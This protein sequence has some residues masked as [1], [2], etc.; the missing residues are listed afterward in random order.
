[1]YELTDDS[2]T[3]LKKTWKPG[4]NL[5]INAMY[6]IPET[7]NAFKDEAYGEVFYLFSNTC[8]KVSS[9]NRSF[10][11]LIESSPVDVAQYHWNLN[12]LDDAISCSAELQSIRIWNSLWKIRQ[13]GVFRLVS[14]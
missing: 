2:S 6:E 9:F 10:S 1:M 3:G 8:Y 11:L 7:A 13:W 4:S 12:L 5:I 14:D